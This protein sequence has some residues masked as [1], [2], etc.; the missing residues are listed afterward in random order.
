MDRDKALKLLRG[1]EDGAREW[2]RRRDA[3]KE[4]IAAE[5]MPRFKALY[6]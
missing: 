1:G 4:P 3:P 6:F 5:P 2:N